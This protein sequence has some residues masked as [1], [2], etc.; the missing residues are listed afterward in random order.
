MLI[1]FYFPNHRLFLLFGGILD[2]G[3]FFEH[4]FLHTLVTVDILP[5]EFVCRGRFFLDLL[6]LI[7]EL[8]VAKRL[9]DDGHGGLDCRVYRV[10]DSG[11]WRG[12]RLVVI[13]LGWE[14]QIL[15]EV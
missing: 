14:L 11:E 15:V 1:L 13:V 3:K 5:V 9:A 4:A 7:V 6:R 8:E 12:R 10:D 2:H